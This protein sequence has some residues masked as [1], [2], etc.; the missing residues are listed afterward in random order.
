[1]AMYR[2]LPAAE[3]FHHSL[4]RFR[5]GF[6]G[7]RSGK[8]ESNVGYD[9]CAFALGIHPARRTPD[10][11]VIWAVADTWP[12]VGKLLW[13]EKISQYLLR[14]HIAKIVWH[15]VGEE[16]PKEIRLKNG[17]AIEFKAFEQGREKFQGRAV[18]GIYQDEQCTHNALAIF[19]EMQARL[20]KP[21]SFFAG[22]LTPIIPQPWL[23]DIATTGKK[24]HEVFYAN[25]NDNRK[26]RGGH[27][28]DSVIDGLIAEWPLEVQATRIEGR[29]ASFFGAVYKTFDKGIHVCEPFTIPDGWRKF[30]GIDFGFNNPFGVLWAALSDDNV[31]VIYAEHYKSQETLRYH[32]ERI[33]AYGNGDRYEATYADHDAQGRRELQELGI[34]TTPARKAVN[35]GIEKVQQALKVQAN[36]KPRLRIFKSCHNLIRELGGY[37]YPDGTDSK[38]PKDEPLKVNDHLVDALRYV[39]YST[40][41]GGPSFRAITQIDDDDDT[42]LDRLIQWS[43]S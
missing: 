1:M 30:R 38:D 4:A 42:K 27:L 6:G 15:N 18:D 24:Q 33:H 28:E 34:E 16:T 43:N 19:Q 29:F 5:W 21:D 11:A 8:S 36:G 23:E 35:D 31:W 20:E 17:V 13:K 3:K 22:S 37:R 41:R 25:L 39:I 12:L 26:S 7:N 2:P 40:E 10:N 9:L 32:S 14:H